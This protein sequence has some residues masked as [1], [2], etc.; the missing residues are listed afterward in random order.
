[1]TAVRGPAGSPYPVSH[2]LAGTRRPA[3]AHLTG[4]FPGWSGGHY[5][6]H[7]PEVGW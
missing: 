6:S 1:M 4:T 5:P 7:I 2:L 3:F